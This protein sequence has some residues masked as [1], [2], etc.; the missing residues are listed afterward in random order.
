MSRKRMFGGRE[1]LHHHGLGCDHGNDYD[2]V[3]ANILR[4]NNY[5]TLRDSSSRTQALD[6]RWKIDINRRHLV[7]MS[8]PDP[9]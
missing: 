6:M 8:Q 1:F 7:R 3:M 9:H 2:I 4:A 5:P